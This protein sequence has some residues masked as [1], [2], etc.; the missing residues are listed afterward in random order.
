V[1][2]PEG[3]FRAMMETSRA[4]SYPPF[5]IITRHVP[6][7]MIWLNMYLQIHRKID[8]I[9]K[10]ETEQEKDGRGES[11]TVLFRRPSHL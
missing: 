4:G 1:Y 8:K 11:D 3:G 7:S 2:A 10:R 6:L 5:D 9:D